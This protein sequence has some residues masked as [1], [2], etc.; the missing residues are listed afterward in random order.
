MNPVGHTLAR[1][2]GRLAG[3]ATH[4]REDPTLSQPPAVGDVLGIGYAGHLQIEALPELQHAVRAVLDCVSSTARELQP[5]VQLHAVGQLAPGADS[6][7]A[8]EALAQDYRLHAIL[9]GSIEHVVQDIAGMAAPGV[10][11]GA[12][13]PGPPDDV[14]AFQALLQ[15]A[16]RVLQLDAAAADAKSGLGE[17]DYEQCADVMLTR[18]DCLL[19]LEHRDASPRPG[20]TRWMVR[21]ARS[22][23]I[24]VIV[25][26]IDRPGVLSLTSGDGATEQELALGADDDPAW[27]AALSQLVKQLLPA[28]AATSFPFQTG[29]FERAFL[30][31]LDIGRNQRYWAE[32]WL[33]RSQPT[34]PGIA[35]L[36]AHVD[37]SM[38][39]WAVW[40][41]HRASGMAELVRG[42]FI[43]CA[44]LGLLAVSCALAA[45]LFP[46]LSTAAKVVEVACFLV[47]LWF[48]ARDRKMRWRDQW[49]FCRQFER[50]LSHAAWLSLVGRELKHELP[51]EIRA[52][53]GG[54]NASWMSHFSRT[55]VR[56]AGIPPLKVD[57]HY[58]RT[59]RSLV[60]D[61]LIRGQAE[62][63]RT[64]TASHQAAD[65]WLERWIWRT[66]WVALLITGTYLALK[67]GAKVLEHTAFADA[68]RSWF[69]G[70]AEQA[71]HQLSIAVSV[72]GVAMPCIAAALASIRSHG[73]HAQ[74]ATRYAGVELSLA[75]AEKLL[76]RFCP[77][78][79]D[80]GV[81]TSR[82]L[83][84]VIQHVVAL[85]GHEST[86]WSAIVQTKELEPS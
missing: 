31:Q 58:L 2:V 3:L 9:P 16:S 83:A 39:R 11:S 82:S 6:L 80:D 56:A 70:R 5:S 23:G 45:L 59:V 21:R 85:L 73:D 24:P 17:T 48:I 22:L 30:S 77:A 10:S 53:H 78:G 18:I 14:A 32:R 67:T 76:D 44:L 55:V 37:A 81:C 15:Q 57:R 64:E 74:L 61:R 20:G 8:R 79:D 7:V 36:R 33:D 68:H 43:F 4:L 46:A 26:P 50:R 71:W 13:A 47:V 34:P 75:E 54:P 72:V 28:R 40:A 49:H 63:C 41:D 12:R 29:L 38:G 1:F 84:V 52:F 65:H 27:K 60:L 35:E 25:I 86:S 69:D 62:Y 42:A 66:F 51:A 19:A